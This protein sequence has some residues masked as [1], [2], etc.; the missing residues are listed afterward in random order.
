MSLSRFYIPSPTSSPSQAAN[1]ST[2]SLK[3]I[4]GPIKIKP[5]KIFNWISAIALAA[6]PVLWNSVVFG[7]KHLGAL[8]NI[9][10][11]G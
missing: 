3:E 7:L 2:I 4:A 1:F 6:D 11:K 9:Y 10:T 8:I 5:A